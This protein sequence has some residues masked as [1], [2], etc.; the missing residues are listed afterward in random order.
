[1]SANAIF[2]ATV[3]FIGIAIFL[4]HIVNTAIKRNKRKDEYRLLLFLSFTAFHFLT[5]L[6]FTFVKTAYTSDAFVIGFYTTFYIFNNIE[7]LLLFMYMVSFIDISK[8]S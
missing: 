3:C 7:L 4:I 2:N 5:Y 6:I 1:M 8:K